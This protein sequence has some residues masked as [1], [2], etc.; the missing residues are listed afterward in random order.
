MLYY[1]LFPLR[2]S[3]GGAERLSLSLVSHHRRGDHRSAHFVA[4][5]AE[6]HSLA[7]R[8]AARRLERP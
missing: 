8:M 5:G 6:S 4:L 7:P 2:D 3:F 1:L